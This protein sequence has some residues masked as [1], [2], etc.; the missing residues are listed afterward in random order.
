MDAAEIQARRLNATEGFVPKMLKTSFIWSQMEQF[1][2]LGKKVLPRIIHFDTGSILHEEKSSAVIFE[3]VWTGLSEKT[4][5]DD[6]E[7]QNNFWSIEGKYTYRSALRAEGTIIPKT[8]AK[9]R[10]CQ[11]DE[12]NIRCIA[13]KPF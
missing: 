13:G 6:R 11:A 5:M 3:E 2:Y 10:R 4:T 12:H 1:N 9:Y 7:A 8:T